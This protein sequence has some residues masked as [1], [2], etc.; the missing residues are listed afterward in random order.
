MV[1]QLPATGCNPACSLLARCWLC[2]LTSLSAERRMECEVSPHPGEPEHHSLPQRRRWLSGKCLGYFS[3]RKPRDAA[4]GYKP[5]C[6]CAQ[7]GCPWAAV[8]EGVCK[9]YQVFSYPHSAPPELGQ[10]DCF[11][12]HSCTYKLRTQFCPLTQK[13]ISQSI[14]RGRLH[15]WAIDKDSV[16]RR[17]TL[18]AARETSVPCLVSVFLFLQG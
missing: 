2:C 15:R 14:Q 8:P 6:P 7:S 18:G 1:R 11:L 12:T 17:P 16:F 4:L 3:L 5:W 9:G 13:P 10:G